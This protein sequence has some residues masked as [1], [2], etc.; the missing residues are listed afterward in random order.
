MATAKTKY[1][2]IAQELTAQCATLPKGTRLPTEKQLASEYNVSRMTIR[3]ALER[4]NEDMVVVRIRGRGTFVQRPRV[5]KNERL[6]SFTEDMEARGIE[7]STRLI[8]L[9]RIAVT[10]ELAQDLALPN[11]EPVVRVHRLRFGGKEPVCDETVYLSPHLAAKLSATDYESSIHTALRAHGLAPAS[12]T[13]RTSAAT[14]SDTV[15]TLLNIPHGSPSLR[16][17]HIFRDDQSQPLYFSDSYYRADR[18][19]M[20]SEV[21]RI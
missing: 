17:K 11:A 1:E 5:T 21:E 13:R 6:T 2:G 7:P 19:E 16:V 10:S 12:A 8:G 15:A 4:L 18:Y 9:D 20:V 3:Q 14:L